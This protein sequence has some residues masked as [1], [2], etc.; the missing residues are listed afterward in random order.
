MDRF[1]VLLCLLLSSL[2]SHAQELKVASVFTDKTVLQQKSNVNIWG[3]SKPS[4]RVEVKS[5]WGGF[6][7][8][9]AN[10]DGDW[11]V[12]IKTPAASYKTYSLE[13]ESGKELINLNDVVCGEVWLVSGQSNMEM[14]F[15]ENP[16]NTLRV[17]GASEVI[18]GQDD[19]F[20]RSFNIARSER[21]YPQDDITPN[22]GWKY[23]NKN[24]VVWFS[25]VGYF[26]AAR[27]RQVLDIPVGIIN[28][29]YGG[30]PIE[31]WVPENLTGGKI[32]DSKREE[33]KEEIH[34][35]SLGSEAA[36][37]RFS[38]WITDSQRANSEELSVK[39]DDNLT[40]L[41]LPNYFYNTP[42]GE[43]LGGTFLYKKVRLSSSSELTLHLPQIDRNCQIFFNG[44]LVHQDILPSQAYRHPKVKIPSSLIKTG[45]NILAVNMI[46]TLWN[47]G[48]VGDPAEMYLK[49][50]DTLISLAGKWC[51]RKT[52]DL[53][54]STKTPLEGL[55]NAFLLSSL[56]NGMIDPIKKFNIKGFLW[57]QGESNISNSEQY[58][59]ILSS[60]VNGWREAW[61]ADLPFYYV[62]IAPW[63]YSGDKNIE[64]ALMRSI[65]SDSCK[66]ITNSEVVLTVDLGDSLS[67][68]PPKKREVGERLALKALSKTYDKKEFNID[69]PYVDG[70]SVKNGRVM[71]S[72]SKTYGKII[73]VPGQSRFELSEDGVKFYKSSF[74]I[75]GNKII[76]NC[77]KMQTPKF[78]R[79][80]F[81]N[82][83]KVNIFNARMLPLNLFSINLL[84]ITSPENGR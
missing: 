10:G 47:G 63:K 20:L 49:S 82:S 28:S 35:Y 17:E 59:I 27:L 22:G 50:A 26:F 48:I 73:V 6:A 23:K 7:S 62:Q 72:I 56:Y 68:H 5:S 74:K 11:C 37:K 51:F 46:T 9:N 25:A 65:M 13:I 83:S 30:T 61:G 67:I 36:M 81:S 42:R 31:S 52:F 54:D 40:N 69:Y 12:S 80:A 43:S 64:G 45:D 14:T 58:P 75:E 38:D 60:L 55:P 71:L 16:L 78:V 41:E 24:D 1:F 3:K 44:K 21:F 19:I 2:L 66:S 53:G 8:C 77:D 32:F 33:R 79:H 18:N 34:L 29:S 84:K 4:A 76:L 70:V 57:Y 39:I 15:Y